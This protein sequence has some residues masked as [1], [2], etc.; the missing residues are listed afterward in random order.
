MGIPEPLYVIK[1][2]P[3]QRYDHQYDEGDRHKENRGSVHHP[4]TDWLL[5]PHTDV[6]VH[7][8]AVIHQ[9]G[10]VVTPLLRNEDRD[11]IVN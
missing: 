11:G 10:D 9:P 6:H 8:S 5:V 4:G 3:G 7:L 1:D 2:K